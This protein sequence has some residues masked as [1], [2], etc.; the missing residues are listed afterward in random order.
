MVPSAPASP[1]SNPLSPLRRHIGRPLGR[2]TVMSIIQPVRY[3]LNQLA[4]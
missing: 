1:T 3:A 4:R 2:V